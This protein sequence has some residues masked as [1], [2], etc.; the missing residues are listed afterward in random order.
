ML[1]AGE[2]RGEHATIGVH[3]S[4]RVQARGAVHY[5]TVR[6]TGSGSADLDGLAADR[7]DLSSTGSGGIMA[8]VRQELIAS[9]TGSGAV[10]VRGNPAQRKISGRNV[11]VID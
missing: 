3:G 5:L 11:Y 10:R 8:N 7:G 6:A 9:S 2:L 4:G 1:Y